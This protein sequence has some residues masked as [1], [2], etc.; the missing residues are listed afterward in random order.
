MEV[1]GF[2][3]TGR[4]AAGLLSLLAVACT[5]TFDWREQLVPGTGI[6]TIFPCRPDRHARVVTL[7]GAPVRMEMLVCAAGSATYAVGFLDVATLDEAPMALAALRVAFLG[8]IQAGGRAGA[9][10]PPEPIGLAIAGMTPNLESGQ[11]SVQG[12]RPDGTSLSARGA[13]FAHGLRVYQAVVVGS[14]LAVD[15]VDPFFAGLKFPG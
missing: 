9:P 15:E 2:R 3:W 14:A 12:R 1:C 5:P 11:W 4:G 6:V 8:N 13:F 10:T 7:R